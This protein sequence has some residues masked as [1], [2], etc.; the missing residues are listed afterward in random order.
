MGVTPTLSSLSMSTRRTLTFRPSLSNVTE[1]NRTI[2]GHVLLQRPKTFRSSGTSS[3]EV[4]VFLRC[5]RSEADDL[6]STLRAIPPE[7]PSVT[8]PEYV[9]PLSVGASWGADPDQPKQNDGMYQWNVESAAALRFPLVDSAAASSF[10]TGPCLTTKSAGFV[11]A[12]ASSLTSTTITET[13]TTSE[14]TSFLI[15]SVPPDTRGERTSSI[16]PSGET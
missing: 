2:S 1:P 10:P 11:R 3:M 8:D 15:A 12:S 14:S 5:T 7:H 6:A 13:P 16:C 4:C 9:L